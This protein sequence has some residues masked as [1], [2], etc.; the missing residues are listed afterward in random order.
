RPHHF[1]FRICVL[2]QLRWR[3]RGF[4]SRS[5]PPAGL[6]RRCGR[7]VVRRGIA[8]RPPWRSP[9]QPQP[10][11]RVV[12]LR[13]RHRR[14]RLRAFPFYY[15][16]DEQRALSGRR[17][18]RRPAN[19][20]TFSM[21][22]AEIVA[23][24]S[25]LLTPQ[26]IDTDSLF[27]TQQLNDLGVE[28]VRKLIVGDDRI[29][30]AGTVRDCLSRAKIV[31]VTGGLGPTEDDVTRD[32]VA[33]ALGRELIFSEE[34]CAALE[35][36]FRRANRKMAEIN[37][38]QAYLVSGAEVLPNPNGTAP[39]Q[40]IERDGSVVMI[41]PGPP[42]E[43]KPLFRDQCASR[44]KSFLPPQSICTWTYRV[45]GLGES[46]LDQLIAP[47]Y[48]QYQNP[49]TTILANAGDIQ[50]LLRARGPWMEEAEALVRELG[51]KIEPLLGDRIYSRNGG[52]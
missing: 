3:G 2:H 36:R 21:P 31:I 5:W 4:L 11:A 13:T 29:R 22:D 16:L 8:W 32:A 19:A 12:S 47:V 45:A 9:L 41:L 40:W 28:V 23:V 42:R 33:A 49:V 20:I 26:R 35:D 44:L 18:H 39:G 46:D 50:V 37:K 51:R 52:T 25:E 34:L 7:P 14:S 6:G 38:R 15:C 17:G 1:E 27:L 24:G 48:T 43:L 10:R 30:L